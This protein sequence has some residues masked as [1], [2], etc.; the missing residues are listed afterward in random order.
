MKK[1]Y[2]IFVMAIMAIVAFNAKADITVTLKV[3]DATRLTA[4]YQYYGADYTTPPFFTYRWQ[5]APKS[6]LS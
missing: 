5:G 4:N 1:F 2:S 3:D 6:C